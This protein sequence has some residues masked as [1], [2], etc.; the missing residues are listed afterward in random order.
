MPTIPYSAYLNLINNP[1]CGFTGG[2][3]PTGPTGPV[4][5]AG[6]QG[7]S[8]GLELYFYTE[9]PTS[10]NPPQPAAGT[11]YASGYTMQTVP[12]AG[13]GLPPGNPVQ[14]TLNGYYSVFTVAS[15]QSSPGTYPTLSTPPF[16]QTA[17][18]GID[19]VL[20]EFPYPLTGKGSIPVGSWT[21][22]VSIFSWDGT[23]PTTIP[24]YVFTNVYYWKASTGLYQLI[25]STGPSTRIPITKTYT[26]N[27]PYVFSVN[28]PT[29]VV[30]DDP[31]NDRV[32]VQFVVSALDGLGNP[33]IWSTNQR[34][35]FWTEGDFTSQVVTS[36]SGAGGTGATGPTGLPGATGPT[37]D[38][39][40]TGADFAFTGPTGSV[41][42]YDGT[43]VTGD[44]NL[45][46][47]GNNVVVN[48]NS[49]SAGTLHYSLNSQN[50]VRWAIG[51]SGTGDTGGSTGTTG[52]DLS[53]FAYKD[54][55]SF[56]GRFININRGGGITDMFY[57]P[58]YPPTSETL[59][60][61]GQT[62][63]TIDFTSDLLDNISG[64]YL[65]LMIC[66]QH[67]ARNNT[68]IALWTKNT[69]PSS[70]TLLHGSNN[71]ANDP[72]QSSYTWFSGGNYTRIFLNTTP[73]TSTLALENITTDISSATH[74]FTITISR[75]ISLPF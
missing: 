31:S 62:T 16:N 67:P 70:L 30:I 64:L 43:S 59:G 10:L 57:N 18:N 20:C 50:A 71:A 60:S 63:K 38:Q 24:A 9:D 52:A 68:V 44:S 66:N 72:S 47:S 4:G 33:Y 75:I 42:F 58:V 7:T 45:T 25:S 28:V 55:T 40:P 19:N 35:E 56:S 17:F 26:D 65:V 12:G 36:I 2:T 39:G 15:Y 48:Q 22:A 14:P 5:P 3:G 51:L 23:N 74:Q 46:T 29:T 61:S 41:L 37:G 21:F 8:S 69:T 1:R 11:R 6:P 49:V 13:P 54:D 73:P 27:T 53:V 34:V 32:W